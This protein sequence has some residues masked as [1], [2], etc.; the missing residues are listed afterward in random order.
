[1]AE[2]R[3]NGAGREEIG[4]VMTQHGTHSAIDIYTE[5]RLVMHFVEK[6]Q[7]ILELK[8]AL[9]SRIPVALKSGPEPDQIVLR[10]TENAASRGEPGAPWR[11]SGVRSR[12]VWPI[13]PLRSAATISATAGH[14]DTTR[15]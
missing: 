8:V 11:N 10:E 4:N 6:L 7:L 1:M 13:F 3:I 14:A 9:Q 2:A 15:S 12:S 5:Q